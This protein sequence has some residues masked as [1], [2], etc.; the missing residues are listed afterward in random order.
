M[1]ADIEPGDEVIMP[2]FAFPSIANAVVLRGAVP[3]FVD[4]R[5]DTLNLDERLLEN[6]ITERTVAVTAVHY[7]GVCAEMDEICRVATTAGLTVFEDAAQAILSTYRGRPAGSLADFGCFSFHQTKN[8]AAGECGVLTVTGADLL[9]RAHAIGDKG[10]NRLA[11]ERGE[12]LN[13]QWVECGSSFFANEVTAAFLYAQLEAAEVLV[14]RRHRLWETYHDGLEEME[15]E[16][17]IRRPA[18]P[19]HCGHNAHIYYVRVNDPNLRN[20]LIE[21][22]RGAGIHASSHFTPLHSSPAGIRFGRHEGPL[23][24]TDRASADIVRLPLFNDL[25]PEA[26]CRVVGEVRAFFSERAGRSHPVG[27]GVTGRSDSLRCKL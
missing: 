10:T 19:D 25:E 16:G 24:E 21:S 12:V 15:A 14:S 13:Y 17:F 2:S 4:V 9:E 8:I 6:A 1:L 20:A 11:F 23:V 26:C 5:S 3:V 18:I 7:A 27:P 22:L